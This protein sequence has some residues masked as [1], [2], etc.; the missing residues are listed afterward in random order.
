MSISEA[1]E[2]EVLLEKRG[3]A[4][5]ITLNRPKQL[6]ALSHQMVRAIYPQMLDWKNDPSVTRVIVRGV[7]EKAFCA[8]GDIR[9]LYDLGKA[10]KIDEA[11]PFWR[12]EYALNHLLKNFPKP[13][14]SL[15]NGIVMGGGVGLSF[16]GSYR[17]GTEKLK[18]AMPEVSIGFFPDVGAS[19]FLPRLKHHVGTYLAI[20]GAMLGLGDA[21]DL[22]LMT[23]AVESK[24]IPEVFNELLSHNSVDLVLE[25]FAMAEVPSAPLAESYPM[26][27]DIFQEQSIAHIIAGLGQM[28]LGG[29]H[30]AARTLD[31]LHQKSP[32][33]MAVALRQMQLGKDM[34]FAEAMQMEYR[35]VSRIIKGD[36]FYE[37]VRAVIIDKDNLPCWK[38]QLINDVTDEIVNAHFMPLSEELVLS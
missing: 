11:L 12:E 22:G 36:D 6:N 7:G 25:R 29:S 16:H 30:F 33:S 26:I 9:A 27:A 2:S 24:N 18:F 31:L 28:A 20:T 23:N 8:G 21:M 35:I 1:I 32:T 37:G 10:G 15:L 19:H 17:V 13:I 34:N 3:F 14:V 38:P 4:G 5:V